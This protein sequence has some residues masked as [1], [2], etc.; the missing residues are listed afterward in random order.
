MVIHN[1]NKFYLWILKINTL[2]QYLSKGCISICN[3]IFMQNG[4]ISSYNCFAQKTCNYVREVSQQF[5]LSF[6]MTIKV[7]YY[8]TWDWHKHYC[9]KVKGLLTS[10]DIKILV[11]IIYIMTPSLIIE[12]IIKY[13]TFS[14]NVTSLSI[15]NYLCIWNDKETTAIIS[16]F[17]FIISFNHLYFIIS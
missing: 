16:D 5:C 10:L 1:L 6:I 13:D 3:Y 7:Y 11:Q 12:I 9:L 4:C 15:F 2:N 14:I 17:Y 8:I